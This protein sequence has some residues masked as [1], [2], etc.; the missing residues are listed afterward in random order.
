MHTYVDH[1]ILTQLNNTFNRRIPSTMSAHKL[2]NTTGSVTLILNED[3]DLMAWKGTNSIVRSTRVQT[4]PNAFVY[5][6]D[7]VSGPTWV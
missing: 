4:A 6:H 2:R 1:K 5:V 3:V 7:H